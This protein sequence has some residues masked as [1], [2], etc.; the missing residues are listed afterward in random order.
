MP[1]HVEK[2]GTFKIGG[3]LVVHRLGFG[4]MRV[5]G[6]GVW[7]EPPDRAEALRTLRRVPELGIDFIDT[8]D[9][10]G[11][12]ISERLLRGIASICRCR[13][14]H[15][16]RPHA[17]RTRRVDSPRPPRVSDPAGAQESAQSRRGTHRLVAAAPHRSEVPRDEQF[18]AIKSL[19]KQGLI[20]F[21]GLSEVSVDNIRAAQKI[22][23]VATVQN[24]YNLGN[25]QSED[26]LD[27]CTQHNMVS[28][29]GTRS[30]PASLRS[31][32]ALDDMR[33]SIPQ[34]LDKSRSRGCSSAVA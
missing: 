18:D 14:C 8:A 20:R 9:S 2:S 4:A 15:Q 26:V 19:L 12:D 25:R 5:T 13:H 17:H 3:E 29:R 32:L 23:P 22:F 34:R 31:R 30:R 16:G 10:Y 7:G 11:P 27:Y 6:A 33:T 1:H 24:L 28:F 21:A